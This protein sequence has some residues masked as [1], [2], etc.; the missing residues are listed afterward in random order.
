MI[1]QMNDHIDALRVQCQQAEAYQLL[2]RQQILAVSMAL[3]PLRENLMDTDIDGVSIDL[4][5]SGDSNTLRDIFKAL[6]N[7]GYIPD[8]RPGMAPQASFSTWWKHETIA[9]KIWLSFASNKCTRT[10]VGT[11]TKVVDV[12]EVVCE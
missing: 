1:E 6:R 2:H 12:F 10:K 5:Y 11:E 9:L 3:A 4:N 7:L 8:S